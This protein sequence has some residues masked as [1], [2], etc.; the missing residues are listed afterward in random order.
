MPNLKLQRKRDLSPFR[1]MALGTWRTSY[2]PTVR[3]GATLRMEAAL[4]YLDAFRA[5]TGKRL[6]VSHLMAKAAGH[7]LAA[8]P[9][10][11]AV[12]RLGRIY[13]RERIGVFFQVAS[14][15]PR[16]G[17][18]DLSGATIFEPHEKSLEAIVDELEQR[19]ASVRG[20]SDE[21]ERSRGMFRWV[22]GALAHPLLRGLGF[23][24]YELNLDLRWMGLPN[25]PFG[26]IMIT[27]IGSLGLEDAYP[28]LVPFSRVPIVV[29]IGAVAD[30]PV[31]E[32]DRIV[33][34]KVMRLSAT[35]DHRILD[36]AHAAKLM[37]EVRACIEDPV[38]RF[39]ALR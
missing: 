23:V 24:N 30:A 35:F 7:A 3:G 21:K 38:G 39:G 11:N 9:D 14:E 12:V 25:D 18:V 15:D 22:P 36:G 4:A 10:A 29:A 28:P 26:S 32:D 19:A 2:D 13:R 20:G 33:P 1:K 31:V 5:A 6:T 27:N 17:E 16:T 34:G 8:V 37:A